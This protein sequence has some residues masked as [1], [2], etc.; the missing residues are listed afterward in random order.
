MEIAG[1]GAI[2]NRQSAIENHQWES[3]GPPG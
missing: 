3:G 2:R 1:S